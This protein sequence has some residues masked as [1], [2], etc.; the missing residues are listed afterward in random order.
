VD[1]ERDEQAAEG[2]V[3]ADHHAQL[4]DLGG[5]EVLLQAREER[6][7]DRA[8]VRGRAL[9]PLDREALARLEV[10]L[11]GGQ[12]ELRDARLVEPLTR[13]RRVAREASGGA[14]VEPG[15]AQARELLDARR[16][17]ALLVGRVVEREVA[18]EEVGQVRQH[19]VHRGI[20]AGSHVLVDELAEALGEEVARDGRQPGHRVGSQLTLS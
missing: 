11:L 12:V 17:H 9:G 14:G 7:V 1:A 20:A 6:V 16:D 19:G 2:E 8:M 10:A 3:L 4:E 18:L 15:D 5:A 13:R